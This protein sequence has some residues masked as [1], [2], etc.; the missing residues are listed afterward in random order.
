MIIT[1]V[2]NSDKNDSWAEQKIPSLFRFWTQ[3]IALTWH[4]C[5]VALLLLNTAQTFCF[6]L[7]TRD[8]WSN[9]FRFTKNKNRNNFGD[10]RFC[11]SGQS[12]FDPCSDQFHVLFLQL[13]ADQQQQRRRRQRQR[14]QEQH[15]LRWFSDVAFA[16]T[17]LTPSGDLNSEC[18]FL[19]LVVLAVRKNM[20]SVV[21]VVVV[22]VDSHDAPQLRPHQQQQ[23]AH[24]LFFW[25]RKWKKI[26][27]NKFEMVQFFEN[28]TTVSGALTSSRILTVKKTQML[29]PSA[30]AQQLLR[31]LMSSR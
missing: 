17:K 22:V 29:P 8:K 19:F 26:A 4:C 7:K 25:R 16:A 31:Q 2:K 28:R 11:F 15:G 10:H 3:W 27:A 5:A 12:C 1:L 20:Q 14:Q 6:Y 23:R 9:Q 18:F 30:K 13:A 24:L 21:V